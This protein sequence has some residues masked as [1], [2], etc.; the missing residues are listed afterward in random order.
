[1]SKSVQKPFQGAL[2][3]YLGVV[4]S[5]IVVKNTFLTENNQI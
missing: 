4:L 2:S 3:Q 1:M 5:Q